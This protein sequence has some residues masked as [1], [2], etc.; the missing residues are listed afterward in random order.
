[1]ENYQD[2]NEIVLEALNMYK[3]SINKSD[4]WMYE[5]EVKIEKIINHLNKK[6]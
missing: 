4:V 5:T 3:N 6:Q 1:M 2:Y